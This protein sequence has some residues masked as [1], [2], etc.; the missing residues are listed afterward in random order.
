[1]NKSIASVSLALAIALAAPVAITGCGNQAPAG[2]SNPGS[3]PVAAKEPQK[4]AEPGVVEI[5]QLKAG[6]KYSKETWGATYE[7][8]VD[9]FG[10][11]GAPY[12]NEDWDEDYEYYEWMTED[13]S[14]SV[15]I[16]FRIEDD[17][18]RAKS[19]V[20]WSGDEIKAYNETL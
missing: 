7:S 9:A 17:G 13:S 8:L 19:G 12:D 4:K 2:S 18:T 15:L 10:N 6:L 11:E 5:D 3:A 20:S 1:M 14:D 16:T